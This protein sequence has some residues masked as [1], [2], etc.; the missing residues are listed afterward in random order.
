MGL[1]KNVHAVSIPH[2]SWCSDFMA[3]ALEMF[4]ACKTGPGLVNIRMSPWI[5]LCFSGLLLLLAD[6]KEISL[7][8]WY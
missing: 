8:D 3:Q 4:M 1:S 2:I 5:R 6:I 7:W